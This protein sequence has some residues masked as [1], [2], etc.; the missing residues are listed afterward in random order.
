MPE[1]A[2]VTRAVLPSNVFVMPA[3]GG[4]RAVYS[5]GRFCAVDTPRTCA[6]FPFRAACRRANTVARGARR[7]GGQR[8]RGFCGVAQ[9]RQRLLEVELDGVRVVRQVAD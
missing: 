9:E 5:E 1:V 2:P 8:D 7:S 3:K 6:E 4:S